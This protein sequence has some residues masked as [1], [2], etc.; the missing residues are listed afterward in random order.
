MH[1]PRAQI[2]IYSILLSFL[3]GSVTVFGESAQRKSVACVAPLVKKKKSAPLSDD[4]V[5]LGFLAFDEFDLSV[6]AGALKAAAEDPVVLAKY[7]VILDKYIRPGLKLSS[8]YWAARKKSPRQWQ[9]EAGLDPDLVSGQVRGLTEDQILYAIIALK[10]AGYEVHQH[11]MR[12]QDTEEAREIIFAAIGRRIYPS[13]LLTAGMQAH[14]KAWRWWLETAG[15]SMDEVGGR[16]EALTFEQVEAGLVAL[17]DLGYSTSEPA[18][19]AKENNTSKEVEILFKATGRKVKPSKLFYD[20]VRHGYSWAWWREHTEE[21]STNATREVDPQPILAAIRELLR[22]QLPVSLVGLLSGQSVE[23]YQSVLR[24]FGRGYGIADLLSAATR[25]GNRPWD[26][27]VR[28]ARQLEGLRE[29]ALEEEEI[30]KIIA[31]YHGQGLPVAFDGFRTSRSAR[32]LSTVFQLLGKMQSPYSAQMDAIYHHG[33]TWASWLEKANIDWQA[34]RWQAAVLQ[35]LLR[36]AAPRL[37][38]L[39]VGDVTGK[40]SQFRARLKPQDAELFDGILDT[41]VEHP[42]ADSK[43]LSYGA[44]VR[45]NRFYTEAEVIKIF[46]SIDEAL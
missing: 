29:N 19:K 21:L 18:I 43:A 12:R 41:L 15:Y 25:T 33:G 4:E 37:L 42:E 38:N 23:D 39:Q 14:G 9:I 10:D 13:A 34:M 35:G 46:R 44:S 32:A 31:A 16:T 45:S 8:F 6:K 5:A 17:Y 11:A 2:L 36:R 20:G 27:W 30:L 40:F 28:E 24:K 7:E 26:Q 22:R 1:L 3:L